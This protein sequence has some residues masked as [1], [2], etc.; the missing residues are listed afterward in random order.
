[1]SFPS[2]LPFLSTRWNRLLSPNAHA[3]FIPQ[4]PPRQLL[5]KVPRQRTC[6]ARRLPSGAWRAEPR[7]PLQVSPG[8]CLHGGWETPFWA[9]SL[10]VFTDGGCPALTETLRWEVSLISQLILPS[11]QVDDSNVRKAKLLYSVGRTLAWRA[12]N[13]EFHPHSACACSARGFQERA[14]MSVKR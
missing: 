1:M 9:W 7:L 14:P 8:S 11:N 5:C 12:R 3:G 4:M 13:P 10:G 6:E 2:C